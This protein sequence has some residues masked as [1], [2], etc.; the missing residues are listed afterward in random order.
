MPRPARVRSQA[1]HAAIERQP[2]TTTDPGLAA[3]VHHVLTNYLQDPRKYDTITTKYV[4]FCH[5]LD[6]EPFPA[7]PIVISAWI[8]RCMTT[9]QPSSLKMYLAAVRY[10]QINTGYPW[11]LGG[12]ESIRRTGRSATSSVNFRRHDH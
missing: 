7:D 6:L 11:A 10:A 2:L 1:R 5:L 3:E 8:V 4:D 9:V 12:D